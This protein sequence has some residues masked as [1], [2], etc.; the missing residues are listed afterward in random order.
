[1]T[2]NNSINAPFPFSSVNIQTFTANGTYTP[3]TGMTY[4]KIQLVG[5]GGGGG[6]AVPSYN[7]GGGGGAGGYS[8]G[9]FTAATVG[10]SQTVTIGALGAGGA[11][12]THNG[13]AGGT[14]SVGSLISAT[15]GSG[16]GG[17]DNVTGI[18]VSGAGGSGSSG[19][20]NL[21]GQAGGIGVFSYIPGVPLE[22]SIGGAG[23]S[24]LF[25]AGGV[26]NY[27]TPGTIG[28]AATGYGSGG[29]GGAANASNIGGGAGT[30]GFVIITEYIY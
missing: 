28:V 14:T 6:G 26:Y 2:T 18:G 12:G 30:A 5:G 11:A 20:V 9:V 21:S 10:A 3:T 23:G 29:S 25:G 1:M 22:F 24:S 27:L 16:G 8:Y 17:A 7:A 4:C 15:G 13:S 19:A